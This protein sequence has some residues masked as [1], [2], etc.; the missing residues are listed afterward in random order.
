MLDRNKEAE[1]FIER[2]RIGEFDDDRLA[3]ALDSLTPEQREGLLRVLEH[4]PEDL[5]RNE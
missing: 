1:E 5:K 2:F 4:M 3:E